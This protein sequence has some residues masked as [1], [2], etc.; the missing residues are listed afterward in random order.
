LRRARIRKALAGVIL[1][2]I[3][4]A[5]MRL[6]AGERT[7]TMPLEGAVRDVLA[8]VQAGATQAGRIVYEGLGTFFSLGRAAKVEQLEKQVRQL[9]GK[10]AELKEYKAENERLRRLLAFRE[11]T[12]G[13]YELLA[14]DVI[15][16]DPGNWF[17]TITIDR[18]AADGVRPY[19]PVLLP[20]GLV[21]RV[22][23]VSQ[24][25]AEVLLITDPRS[26]VGGAVQETRT[27]GVLRGIV[28]SYGQ[29]RMTYL[30]K[31]APVEKGHTV[32]TSG[33]GG[34]F[35]GGIPVGKITAV[36][37]EPTGVTKEAL[38]EPLVN[39][40]HLEEVLIMLRA[41]PGG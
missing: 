9:E 26:G 18:G 30:A 39:F 31:D 16:R 37:P 10:I 22:L 29:L 1:L 41:T 33:L 17:G 3:I 27:P 38:V 34:A 12:R 11:E 5:V 8:P 23:R 36:R 2:G 14:A 13:R 15:A 20:E 40:S 24:H 7:A 25:T 21:G 35:P 19:M 28:N 4:F 6:T 32:V